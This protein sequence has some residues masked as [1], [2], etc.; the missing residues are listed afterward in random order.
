MIKLTGTLLTVGLCA[1]AFAA[2]A[3]SSPSAA[4]DQQLKMIEGELMP[5]AEAMPADKYSFAPKDGEFKTVRTF[6]QQ[7]GHIGAVIYICGASVLGEPVPAAAGKGESGPESLKTKDDYIKYLKA[8][9]AYGHK[10]M[11]SVTAK[12]MMDTIKSP[13]GGPDTA[14]VSMVTAPVWHTFDHYGQIVIYARMNGIVP[15]ASRQ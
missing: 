8:A 11:N 6:G 5:L 12:N 15:P 13:F 1:A 4:F 2:D 7:L 3:T 9:F 10:A 14:R